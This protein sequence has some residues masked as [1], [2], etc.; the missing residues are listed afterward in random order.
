MTSPTESYRKQHGEIRVILKQMEQMLNRSR[1]ATDAES[2]A[3]AVRELGAKI[4]VHLAIE[5][6]ALYPRMIAQTDARVS[7]VALRF[8]QEMGTLKSTFDDF[9]KSWA[10]HS[11]IAL[12]PEKFVAETS[13]I[14]AALRRRLEREETELYDLYDK[15]A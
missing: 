12:S 3:T 4:A 5:D 1:A 9:R 6:N 10:V 2:M 11:A 13:K 7:N 8:K 14:L 15:V